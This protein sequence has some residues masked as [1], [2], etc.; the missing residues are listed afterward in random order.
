MSKPKDVLEGMPGLLEGTATPEN[1]AR[2]E[3]ALNNPNDGRRQIDRFTHQLDEYLQ[4]HGGGTAQPQPPQ[5]R[6]TNGQ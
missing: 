3:D 2:I 4:R 5:V 1:L 6:T